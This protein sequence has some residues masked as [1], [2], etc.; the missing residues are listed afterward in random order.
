MAFVHSMNSESKIRPNE[1]RPPAFQ[2]VLK[3]LEALESVTYVLDSD[4]RL[5]YCNLAWDK[6]ALENGG[7]TAL[8]AKVLGL[9]L[10]DAIPDVL[11][12]FYSRIFNQ[13]LT[14]GLVWQHVYECSSSQ[15]FRKFRMRIHPFKSEWILV[16]NALVVEAAHDQP[17]V[18]DA[19]Y[20]NGD[21]LIVMCAHCR[22]S[23]RADIPNLWDFVPSH[24]DVNPHLLG[25]SN[26]ICPVCRSYFFSR[27]P[28]S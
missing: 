4:L 23:Q 12:P 13:V 6:F 3:A 28:T 9:R 21:N 26:G 8:S 7:E 24:L 18:A 22:C 2:D 25:V 5:V 19:V 10:F 20:R 15:M 17:A 16:T 1:Q 14:T 11:R 27:I